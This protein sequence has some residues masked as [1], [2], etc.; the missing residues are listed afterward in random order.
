MADELDPAIEA[1]LRT[2]LHAEADSLPM[3][4]RSDDIGRARRRRRGRRFALPA[5]LLGLAAVLAILV[6][7]GV[8]G[9]GDHAPVG[10]SPSPSASP[11]A[12][13]TYDE[14]KKLA[15]TATTPFLEGEH[16]DAGPSDATFTLALGSLADVQAVTFGVNCL[17][18]SI[19]LVLEEAGAEIGTTRFG[20]NLVPYGGGSPLSL[21]G[22]TIAGPID[23]IVRSAANV[24]W[25]IVVAGAAPGATP[26]VVQPSPTPITDFG[27]PGEAIVVST[28]GGPATPTTIVV[29]AWDYTTAGD[30]FSSSLR[31][32]AR[33]PGDLLGANVTLADPLGAKLSPNGRLALSVLNG[34]VPATL[35]LDLSGEIRATLSVEGSADNLGFGPDGMLA[36]TGSDG[37]LTLETAPGNLVRVPVSGIEIVTTRGTPIWLADGSGVLAVRYDPAGAP[38][39]GVVSTTG[40]H[41]LGPDLPALFQATGTERPFDP[42]G[43]GLGLGCDTGGGVAGGTCA[44]VRARGDEPP[45]PW[46]IPGDTVQGNPVWAR[47]GQRAWLILADRGGPLRVVL[48]R[49]AGIEKTTVPVNN[50]GTAA[51][52][53]PVL[54]GVLDGDMSAPLFVVDDGG[55]MTWLVGTGGSIALPKNGVFA[56]WAGG[57]GLYPAP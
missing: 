51:T 42:T 4:I 26:L 56:G 22:E 30:G 39:F 38:L 12:L 50:P 16:P 32:L 45:E 29:E 17:G 48:A 18:G 28:E 5:S 43:H 54:L 21:R 52:G 46:S 13:A 35:V 8:I 57:A 14:L 9:R 7:S 10:G 49:R 19:E 53:A 55:T 3:L 47:D 25:R 24:R 33:V 6:A 34:D 36:T 40:W 44:L 2:A 15:G 41:Q 1:R 37:F 11:R 20:C 23:V 31:T 27:R